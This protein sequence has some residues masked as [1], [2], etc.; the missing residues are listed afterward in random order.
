MH[1]CWVECINRKQIKWLFVFLCVLYAIKQY[2]GYQYSTEQA[3]NTSQNL[4]HAL[5][6]IN[7]ERYK[8]V[9]N[10]FGNGKQSY[11]TWAIFSILT[12]TKFYHIK[13]AHL[14]QTT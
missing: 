8:T 6:D 12:K 2:R 1:T 10:F 7:R 14:W 13:R 11:N 9:L 4:K 5:E 3:T